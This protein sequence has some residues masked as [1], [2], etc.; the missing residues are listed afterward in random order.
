VASAGPRYPTTVLTEVGPS[1][2]NDWTDA[3]FVA[4]NDTAEATITAPTFDAGDTSYRLKATNFGFDAVIAAGDTIT[5]ITV[6][7]ERDAPAGTA[8]D[9]EVRLYDSTGTLVGDNK[10]SATSWPTTPAIATYGSSSDTWAASLDAADIRSSGFGVSLI[11]NADA[12]NTDIG[13][14]FIRVTIEYTAVAA[15]TADAVT[16]EATGAAYADTATVEARGTGAASATAEA[17]NAAGQVSRNALAGVAEATASASPDTAKVQPNATA[18]ATATGATQAGAASVS[19]WS[20][21]AAATGSGLD[22][23]ADTASGTITFNAQ[24]AEGTLAAIAARG[25]LAA[26]LGFAAGRSS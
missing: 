10:A 7:I 24:V 19:A 18:T 22:A 13:V 26:S 1:G 16:A 25:S 9:N 14:D 2:G 23:T 5:G 20:G 3:A 6:E 12:N 17:F 4:S 15:E 21:Y 8:S 11:V